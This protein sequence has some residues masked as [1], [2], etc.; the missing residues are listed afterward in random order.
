M[1]LTSRNKF[2]KLTGKYKDKKQPNLTIRFSKWSLLS[3]KDL[4]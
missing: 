1:K 2:M 3:K 4:E